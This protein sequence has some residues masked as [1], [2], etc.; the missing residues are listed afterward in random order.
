MAITD[1]PDK[2]H[3]PDADHCDHLA[4]IVGIA[5]VATAFACYFSS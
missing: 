2:K 5:K 3:L 4:M 1:L